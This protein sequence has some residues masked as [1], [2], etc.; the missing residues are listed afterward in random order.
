MT[1]F[2]TTVIC[3]ILPRRCRR[4]ERVVTQVRCAPGNQSLANTVQPLS[5]RGG[6]GSLSSP[7]PDCFSSAA[8]RPGCVCASGKRYH[9]GL[10]ASTREART[11]GCPCRRTGS[12]TG[13]TCRARRRDDLKRGTT[14][15]PLGIAKWRADCAAARFSAAWHPIGHYDPQGATRRTDA[16]ACA[17]PSRSRGDGGCCCPGIRVVQAAG[18]RRSSARPECPRATSTRYSRNWCIHQIVAQEPGG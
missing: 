16:G 13:R 4:A 7:L 1:P 14:F 8:S 10:R 17:V 6:R 3:R 9:C 12:A 18:S 11:L 2:P 15:R 5:R